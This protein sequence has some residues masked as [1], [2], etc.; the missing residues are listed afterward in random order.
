MTRQQL[1]KGIYDIMENS[2]ELQTLSSFN[3][4]ARLNEDLYMDSIMV[5]QLILHIELDLGISIPD[6]VL[7][8]KDFKTVGTLANF[9]EKQQKVE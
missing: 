2:L 9:L 6:E 5:L 4:D 3:E 8:P 1:I 7:V